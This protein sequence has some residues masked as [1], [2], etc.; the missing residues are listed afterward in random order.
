MNTIKFKTNINCDACLSK[1]TPVL[2]DNGEIGNWTVDLGNPDKIL[3][4]QAEALDEEE[5]VHS[6]KKVG[7][8]AEKLG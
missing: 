5:L 8:K 2:N 3:T 7:Y 6:L 1:V 4:V